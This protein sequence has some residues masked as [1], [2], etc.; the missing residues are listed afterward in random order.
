MAAGIVGAETSLQDC[1]I[2]METLIRNQ[3]TGT[4]HTSAKNV[5]NMEK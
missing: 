4:T 1:V 3:N 5:W 2:G